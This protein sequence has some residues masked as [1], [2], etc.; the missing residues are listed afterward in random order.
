MPPAWQMVQGPAG[1]VV[2]T[3]TLDTDIDGLVMKSVYADQSPKFSC[4]GDAT[5]WGYHGYQ[6]N[7]PTNSIPDM[8]PTRVTDPATFITTGYRFFRA[9]DFPVA[10][11]P[12]LEERAKNPITTSVTD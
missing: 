5:S 12:V 4:T 7:S 8:D 6:I 3:S 11:A 2:S 10:G 9:D 1:S